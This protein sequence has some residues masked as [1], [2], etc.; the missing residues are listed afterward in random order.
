MTPKQR[1]NADLFIEAA[2][3][4][5]G[6]STAVLDDFD[7]YGN[8]NVFITLKREEFSSFLKFTRPLQGLVKQLKTLAKKH[9]CVIEWHEPPK[10]IYSQVGGS[11]KLWDGYDTDSYK[12]GVRFY[13]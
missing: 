5:V 7:N 1:N 4:L 10:R 8:A 9:A 2:K 12:L 13:E 11:R 6:V 3:T